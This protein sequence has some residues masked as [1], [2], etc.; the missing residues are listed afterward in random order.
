MCQVRRLEVRGNIN[1]YNLIS[2]I[3]QLMLR[4]LRGVSWAPYRLDRGANKDVISSHDQ[5]ICTKGSSFRSSRSPTL[6]RQSFS[7]AALFSSLRVCATQSLSLFDLACRVL[8]SSHIVGATKDLLS[9]HPSLAR[10][11]SPLLSS[12]HLR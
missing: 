8:I 1:I 6:F 2:P 7:R 3:S 11:L 4:R 10:G 12:H 5:T 9:S